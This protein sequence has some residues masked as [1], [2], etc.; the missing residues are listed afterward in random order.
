MIWNRVKTWS[1]VLWVLS[2]LKWIQYHSMVI[3]AVCVTT[4][5]LL[6]VQLVAC[7]QT[8]LG[9]INPQNCDDLDV[10]LIDNCNQLECTD[11]LSPEECTGSVD[12]G[13]MDGGTDGSMDG[14]MDGNIDGSETDGPSGSSDT[15][16]R[17]RTDDSGTEDDSG[18][19]SSADSSRAHPISPFSY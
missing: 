4:G 14:N 6:T 11:Y 18:R 17:S 5:I 9:V 1:K 3:F 7:N 10:R 12:G 8:V 13:G 2:V 15:T 16:D 19:T